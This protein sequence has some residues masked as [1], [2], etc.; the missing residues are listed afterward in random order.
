MLHGLRVT[1]ARMLLETTYLP[2]E[3]VAERCGWRDL[4]MLREVFRRATGTTP[5]AYR[6]RHRLRSKR[7]EWGRDMA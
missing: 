6:E 4:A 2:L 5:A 3:T 1:R 7:R